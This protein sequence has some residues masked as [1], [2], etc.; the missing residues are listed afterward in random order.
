M[1]L[2]EVKKQEYDKL[3]KKS[4]NSDKSINELDEIVHHKMHEPPSNDEIWPSNSIS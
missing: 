1:S 4:K 2:T 3:D